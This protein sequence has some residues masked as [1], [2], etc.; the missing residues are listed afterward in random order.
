MSNKHSSLHRDTDQGTFCYNNWGAPYNLAYDRNIMTSE[1]ARLTNYP[2]SAI[3]HTKTY[4][5]IDLENLLNRVFN[6][7]SCFKLFVLYKSL[8]KKHR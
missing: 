6:P 4:Q 2:N 1:K 8:H 5:K 7:E 3:Y